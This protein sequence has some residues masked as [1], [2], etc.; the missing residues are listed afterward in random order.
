MLN[1]E[2]DSLVLERMRIVYFY[3][4][5]AIVSIYLLEQNIYKLA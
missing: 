2:Y 1:Y 5:F 3:D 4:S